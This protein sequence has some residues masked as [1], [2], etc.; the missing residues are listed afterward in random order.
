MKPYF[1]RDGLALFLGDC[2]EIMPELGERRLE[3]NV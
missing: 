3:H 1:E 2:R